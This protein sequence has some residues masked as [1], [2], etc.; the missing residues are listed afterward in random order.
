MRS[1]PLFLGGGQ[2]GS[3]GAP[4]GLDLIASIAMANSVRADR[5]QSAEMLSLVLPMEVV[6]LR[7]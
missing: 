5:E 1:D 3:C 4:A 7:G 6:L 2:R